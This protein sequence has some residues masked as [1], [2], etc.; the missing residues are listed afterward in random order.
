MTFCLFCQLGAFV[1]GSVSSDS[2]SLKRLAIGTLPEKAEISAVGAHGDLMWA[3][4]EKSRTLYKWARGKASVQNNFE[5][6]DETGT[7]R[8]P[9]WYASHGQ[10]I[11]F[12]DQRTLW[13]CDVTSSKA[14]RVADLT[15]LPA[16]LGGFN[17]SRLL[18]SSMSA[19]FRPQVTVI[20]FGSA[21]ERSVE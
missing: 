15:S 12:N 14:R 5:C 1:L 21:T 7:P 20:T 3:Y 11:A 8:S 18:F 6:R 10:T 13:L 19:Q 2:L 17:E 9:M 16:R 4:D